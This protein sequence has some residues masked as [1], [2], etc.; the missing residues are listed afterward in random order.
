MTARANLKFRLIALAAGYI[1]SPVEKIGPIRARA[2]L[3][4]SSTGPAIL[5]GKRPALASVTDETV[6][7]VPARRYLPH[8]ARPGRIAFFHGGGW[9]LGSIESHDHLA[10]TLAAQSGHEVVSVEYRLAPE[11][12]FPAGLEDCIAATRHLAA[13]G[14]VAVA[15]DSAGGNLAA[16]VANEVP[17]LGQFLMYPV[18]DSAHETPSHEHYATGHL[19]TRDTMRHFRQSY[20]P[21]RTTRASARVSPLRNPDLAHS[22]PAFISV[23]QCDILRDEGVAYADRLRQ[24]GVEV[25]FEEVA[26][27][28]HGFASLLGLRE[29]QATVRKGSQWLA[30][31]LA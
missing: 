15:G 21:D 11:H 9:M 19:L 8:D 25:T 3:L 13:T 16:V 14:K 6:A 28:L 4:K 31:K 23:A 5:T 24:A 29:A 10:A 17:V 18:T 1:M 22:A 26:G 2:D 7:G 30:S 12:P 27:A 20:A